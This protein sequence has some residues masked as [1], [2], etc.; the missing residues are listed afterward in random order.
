MSAWPV[1][2]QFRT[3]SQ[4]SVYLVAGDVIL[5]NMFKKGRLAE[6]NIIG[7]IDDVKITILSLNVIEV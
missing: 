2:Y 7:Q 3:E 4:Q 5:S 1:R 6:V